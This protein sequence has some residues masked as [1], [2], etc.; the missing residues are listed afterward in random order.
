ML[1][2]SRSGCIDSRHTTLG[3]YEFDHVIFEK[4]NACRDLVGQTITSSLESAR[5]QLVV[6]GAFFVPIIKLPD[7]VYLI[8]VRLF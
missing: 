3:R 5:K 2:F 8:L 6:Q 7:F 4:S 1:S